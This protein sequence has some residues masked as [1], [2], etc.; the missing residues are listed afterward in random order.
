MSSFLPW[1]F[2]PLLLLLLQFLLLE[3][4]AFSATASPVLFFSF[5]FWSGVGS[6]AKRLLRLVAGEEEE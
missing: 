2:F 6:V 3:T 4:R 1:L 5:F